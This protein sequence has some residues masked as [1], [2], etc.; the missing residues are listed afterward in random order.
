MDYPAY[1]VI[2][3]AFKSSQDDDPNSPKAK[4]TA[5]TQE[6]LVNKAANINHQSILSAEAGSTGSDRKL[7]Q[8]AQLYHYHHQKQQ[9]ISSEK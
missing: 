6:S 9:M 8:S 2:G 3:P 4:K 7:A 5:V 1:G